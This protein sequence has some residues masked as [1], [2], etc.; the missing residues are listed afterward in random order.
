M[1]DSITHTCAIY[2]PCGNIRINWYKTDGEGQGDIWDRGERVNS[3]GKYL[4][5]LLTQA[6]TM[7]INSTNFDNTCCF[8]SSFLVINEFTQ[9]EIGYYWCQIVTPN[10]RRLQNSM[11][12]FISLHLEAIDNAQTCTVSDYIDRLNPPACSTDRT[13][14]STS[15]TRTCNSTEDVTTATSTTHT[16]PSIKHSSTLPTTTY[17]TSTN[18]TNKPL[19]FTPLIA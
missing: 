17:V 14:F 11:Y 16:P 3:S 9:D 13:Y 19:Q 2:H 4:L 12:A 8:A 10:S 6:N 15:E 18:L 7:V 1:G 5:K